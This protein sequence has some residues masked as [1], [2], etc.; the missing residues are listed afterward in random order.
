MV[1]I[2]G[3]CPPF[4][5][6]ILYILIILFIIIVIINGAL[7]AFCILI[8]F[9]YIVM[10]KIMV[11]HLLRRFKTRLLTMMTIGTSCGGWPG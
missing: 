2:N 1:T 7:P 9:L 8:I 5:I 3:A 10:M 6:L 11:W 4:C